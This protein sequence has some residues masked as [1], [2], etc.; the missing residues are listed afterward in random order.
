MSIS[1]LHGRR[2]AVGSPF[3]FAPDQSGRL[4]L[5]SQAGAKVLKKAV[6]ADVSIFF[7]FEVI[8]CEI[9][10]VSLQSISEGA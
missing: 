5:P 9:L 4:R 3:S 10:F 8:L 1:V 6:S 7:F 2:R